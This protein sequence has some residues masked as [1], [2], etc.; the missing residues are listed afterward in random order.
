MY[1]I[2]HLFYNIYINIQDKYINNL[3]LHAFPAFLYLIAP[4]ILCKPFVKILSHS[5]SLLDLYKIINDMLIFINES[6]MKKS[7]DTLVLPSLATSQNIVGSNPKF[8][9]A[10]KIA[11]KVAMSNANILLSGESGT[12]KEIFARFIHNE[13][14]QKLG[15]FIAFN[16][17]AI[18]ENLM[19]SELFGHSK[20]SF[21]GAF[22]KRVGLFE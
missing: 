11:K 9:L 8:V 7:Q 16:C 2:L 10:L 17:S 15:P 19:E 5:V 18:P 14:K 22:E 6:E 20:G 12:G 4:W 3:F 1:N 21:T 13:S